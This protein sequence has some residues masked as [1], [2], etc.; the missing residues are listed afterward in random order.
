MLSENLAEV[1]AFVK[2]SPHGKAY[3]S[4]LLCRVDSESTLSLLVQRG[5]LK[6]AFLDSEPF[7]RL[8]PEGEQALIDWRSAAEE[9]R[10]QCAEQERRD[11]EQS[12]KDHEDKKKQ[13]RHD[14]LVA[15][16]GAAVGSIIT[17]FIDHFA[18]VC[19][20]VKKLIDQILALF[21]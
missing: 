15:S 4:E 18:E 11:K 5:L 8:T 1:L 13:L 10:R 20:F 2:A 12:A 6:S 14:L 19:S 17:G 16:V 7:Y 21:H 3:R 9:T